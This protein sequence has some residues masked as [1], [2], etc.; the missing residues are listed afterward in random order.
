M[1]NDPTNT[2][3]HD[4]SKD[5]ESTRARWK[6]EAVLTIAGYLLDGTVFDIRPTQLMYEAS[7]L[8]KQVR[9][10]Q[11]KMDPKRLEGRTQTVP[12]PPGAMDKRAQAD[13]LREARDVIDRGEFTGECWGH[14]KDQ[15]REY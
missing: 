15:E 2:N 7:L 6:E 12:R 8:C 11:A 4:R 5:W 10:G 3:R 1:A 14:D 13:A 9:R